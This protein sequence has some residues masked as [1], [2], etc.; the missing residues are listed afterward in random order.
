MSI[1]GIN[2]LLYVTQQKAESANEGALDAAEQQRQMAGQQTP[3]DRVVLSSSAIDQL[4]AA[5]PRNVVPQDPA[6]APAFE[7]VHNS[8]SYSVLGSM[9]GAD[10]EA[11]CF[12]VMMEASKSAREDLKAIMDGVKQI[13]ESRRPYKEMIGDREP[14]RPKL[15]S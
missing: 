3:L 15:A 10:I 7:G 11:L 1:H 13:N 14:H 9:N 4:V 12:I 5:Q 2:S 6:G 8:T